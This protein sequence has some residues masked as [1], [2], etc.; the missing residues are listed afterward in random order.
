MMEQKKTTPFTFKD[1]LK[2]SFDCQVEVDPNQPLFK[3]IELIIN[4]I[5][6]SPNK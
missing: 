6:V 2:L 5:L 4:K 3:R 1:E